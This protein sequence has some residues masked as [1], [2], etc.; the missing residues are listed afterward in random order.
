[1]DTYTVYW[2]E[3]HPTTCYNP[4][5]FVGLPACCPILHLRVGT[6]AEWAKAAN[7]REDQ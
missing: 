2:C 3:A 7:D 4:S 6:F 1:M 5:A